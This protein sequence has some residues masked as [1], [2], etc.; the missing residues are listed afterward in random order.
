MK[1][2]YN[3]LKDFVDIRISAQALADKL[4]MAGLEVTSLQERGGDFILEI[5]ITSN[6]PD[7]LS[8]MGIARE[9]AA[10]TGRK[11]KM[12][13]GSRLQAPGSR[14]Q[15]A[16]PDLR[17]EIE[18]KADCPLYTARIIRN[19]K[20]GP[21]PEWLKKRLELLGCRSVNSVVDITNYVLFELGEPLH[22]FDLDKIIHPQAKGPVSAF[23]IVV[24]RAGAKEKITAIDAS[25]KALD[26]DILVIASGTVGE[27][28]RPL[29]IAGIMGGKETEVTGETKNILLEAAVFSPITVRLGRQKLGL[30]TESSYRFERGVDYQMVEQAS[31]RAVQLIERLCAGRCVSAKSCGSPNKKNKQINLNLCSARKVLGVDI[32]TPRIKGILASLGFKVK[33][34]AKDSFLVEVPAYRPDVNL[35]IDLTE[36]IARIFGY[37]S[38]PTTLPRITPKIGS[39]G[40]QDLVSLT[41]NILVGLGLKEVITYSLIDRGLLN[42]WGLTESA[43]ALEILN[44]LSKEQEVLRPTIIP[45]LSR[46][47]GYNLNQKQGYVNIFEIG[48]I[49]SGSA[50][51]PQEEL[52]LC[53]A[54]CG[55]HALLLKQG[56]VKEEVDFLHLKGILE[57]LFERLGIKDCSFN[58][59]DTHYGISVYVNK[60]NVGILTR[61]RKNILEKFDI[62]NKEVFLAEIFLDRLFSYADLN[63]KAVVLPIYPG[64]SRDISVILR[65]GIALEDILKAV[66]DKGAPLLREARVVDYYQGKQ[67]PAGFRGLTISCLYRSDERTLTE[68]EINPIHSLVSFVLADKFSAQIRRA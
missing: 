22:A 43:S 7:C 39:V 52:S 34:K 19:V 54:L 55:T 21:S 29:A 6:R 9:V 31:L 18:N 1:V 42:G 56:L 40:T 53:I 48:K 17:L 12:A 50:K 68:V 2:T 33:P 14:L 64:I 11:L 28:S 44:P 27:T 15:V 37:E 32:T 49:F 59:N 51:Q 65:E 57:A 47:V 4:T 13:P 20:V 46:C 25:E 26:E 16:S 5:E 8:V 36:E 60:E 3:W 24:R 66:R 35:E 38:I 45:G 63:K 62:K 10:I 61:L 41:K 30:Q 67:I 58:T 23:N